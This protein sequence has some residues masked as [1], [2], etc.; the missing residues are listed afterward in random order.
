[1]PPPMLKPH[2]SAAVRQL[3]GW[4]TLAAMLVVVA[5]ITQALTF[6]FVH[7]TDVRTEQLRPTASTE[8][9]VVG[10]PGPLQGPGA[11]EIPDAAA[12]AAVGG[13]RTQAL[14]RAQA[15]EVNTART[16]WD[17][18]LNR[19]SALASGVG[20]LAALSLLFLTSLGAV[21]G[22]GGGIPGIERSVTAAVWSF[23]LAALCIPIRD[24]LPSLPIPGVF[25]SYEA[26]THQSS[27]WS[28]TG[29]GAGGTIAQWVVAPLL[30]SGSAAMIALWFR[31]GVARGIIVTSVSE[32]D[33]IADREMAQINRN[34][35][36]N[37]VGKSVGALNRALGEQPI[38]QAHPA[39]D[40]VDQ[41]AE[42]ASSLARDSGGHRGVEQ[43]Q[44]VPGSGD[45]SPSVPPMPT[46]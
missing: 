40:A 14:S 7:Y 16:G 8:L 43:Q 25:A 10:T 17:M 37:A 11:M 21:V 33:E 26:M 6:G 1:M 4:V 46:G 44:G 19:A 13:L 15:T 22:G 28:T 23:V 34:G 3:R 30:A 29:V 32:L 39:E 41:A 42:I 45:D 5:G 35:V 36:R 9:T 20:G 12:Q 2:V 38:L 18:G 27:V 31:T 24:V